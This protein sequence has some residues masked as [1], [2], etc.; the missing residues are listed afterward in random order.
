VLIFRPVTDDGAAE[1]GVAAD[2]AAAAN[3]R[4][5]PNLFAVSQRPTFL[6]VRAPV[7]FNSDLITL[8]PT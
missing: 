3:A 4:H 1:A 5:Q 6:K 8:S 2:I 7:R